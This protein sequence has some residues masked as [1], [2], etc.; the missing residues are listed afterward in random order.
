MPEFK[1]TAPDGRTFNVTAP[2]GA[3]R[4]QAMEYAQKN[5]PAPSGPQAPLGPFKYQ[6]MSG[7]V[8]SPAAY[9]PKADPFASQGPFSTLARNIPTSPAVPLA[10]ILT[11]GAVAPAIG[12]PALAGQMA[13]AGAAGAVQMPER[14]LIGA[15][16][17]AALTGVLGGVG[18]VLGKTLG[19]AAGGLERAKEALSKAAEAIRDKVPQGVK[20]FEVPTLAKGRLTFDEAVAALGNARDPKFAMAKDEFV[21]ELNRFDVKELEKKFLSP[22]AERTGT[23]AGEAFAA[24][25]PEKL[26][27]PKGFSQF[28]QQLASTPEGRLLLG[29]GGVGTG[30]GLAAVSPSALK[31]LMHRLP[32]P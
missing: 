29:A 2:E 19:R 11:G 15:A 12:A 4:E 6:G 21:K 31:W 20:L 17:E 27:D 14:P 7:P 26:F 25:A 32:L 22:A 16:F 28:A 5:M 30:A 18:S 9:D 10:G 23:A 24:G 13:G 8:E 3:T 1:I